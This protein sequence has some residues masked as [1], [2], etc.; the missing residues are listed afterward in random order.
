MPAWYG[1]HQVSARASHL[2]V[3][4]CWQV[5]GY[6]P[7]YFPVTSPLAAIQPT[8][9]DCR[10]LGAL[11][12]NLWLQMSGSLAGGL[13]PLGKSAG[14][15]SVGSK[16]TLA[17]GL[18]PLTSAKPTASFRNEPLEGD[19]GS[20]GGWDPQE[21]DSERGKEGLSGGSRSEKKVGSVIPAAMVG[22]Y[23]MRSRGA[24]KRQIL[25]TREHE[26]SREQSKPQPQPLSPLSS[27]AC[28]SHACV[29]KALNSNQ[30]QS[31]AVV[32]TK[33]ATFHISLHFH[34]FFY[35]HPHNV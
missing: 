3:P 33:I 30:P 17:G 14:S 25:C 19:G 8:V 11:G 35:F 31:T 12:R 4:L 27:S 9:A 26:L 29:R 10:G 22:Q 21:Q 6:I 23:S 32:R 15:D 2:L 28:F 16:S 18:I 1:L 7:N 5:H 24:K 20:S 13:L 34:P